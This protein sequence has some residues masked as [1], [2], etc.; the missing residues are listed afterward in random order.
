MPPA[1]SEKARAAELG[2]DVAACERAQVAPAGGGGTLRLRLREVG[3]RLARPRPR[4][5]GG[6][7]SLGGGVLALQEDLLQVDAGLA[8]VVGEVRV[9]VGAGLCLRHERLR[10]QL[11][12]QHLAAQHRALDVAPQVR[13]RHPLAPQL[14]AQVVVVRDVVLL[15]DPVDHLVEVGRG[16]L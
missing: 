3:E 13:D 1:S 6:R 8:G 14:C 15:L 9:V 11:A 12:L 10:L 4:H 5:Q 7:A 2:R 16:T